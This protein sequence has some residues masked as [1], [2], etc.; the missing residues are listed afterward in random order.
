MKMEKFH[1]A[2]WVASKV[3]VFNV[4]K[5]LSSSP[6]SSSPC[7]DSAPQPLT[8]HFCIWLDGS[9]QAIP[10]FMRADSKQV[11]FGTCHSSSRSSSMSRT[12]WRG[13]CSSLSLKPPSSIF[14]FSD[15]AAFFQW[16]SEFPGQ[17]AAVRRQKDEKKRFGFFFS[18]VRRS[19]SKVVP[20]A[21]YGL[22]TRWMRR[23]TPPPPPRSPSLSV[24]DKDTKEEMKRYKAP[25]PHTG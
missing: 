11:T 24:Y 14:P 3:Q 9:T 16:V 1:L 13:G 18:E 12:C 10:F 5:L 19:P 20:N 23:S 22:L 25:S 2:V 6:S 7:E 15:R 8:A 17:S 4:L 21:P